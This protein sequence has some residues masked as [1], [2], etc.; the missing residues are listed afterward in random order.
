MMILGVIGTRF[1]DAGLKY[2]AVQSEVTAEGSI[3]KV[4]LRR[5]LLVSSTMEQLDF[6]K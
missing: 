1:G 5:F 2:L 6:T 4:L 3:E